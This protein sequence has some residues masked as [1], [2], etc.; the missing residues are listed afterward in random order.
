MRYQF[1]R[2]HK[3][4][5]AALNNLERLI[6]QTDFC[7]PDQVGKVEKTFEDLVNMLQ[8]HAQY[9]N[10]RLH[11]LLKQKNV[12]PAIYSH[13]EEDHI[14]QDQQLLKLEEILRVIPLQ[15]TNDKKIE[16]GH[17]L[18]LAYR[19]FVADNLA[20]LHEE[21]IQILPTLQSLY[22]DQELRQVEAQTYREMTP[23]EMIEMIE[24]LFP[25]MNTY[26]KQAFLF[27]IFS[28]EPKKFDAVLKAI[29]PLLS[30]SESN[31]IKYS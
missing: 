19:K 8:G 2:E 5:S 17:H 24:T 23:S 14:A 20:H 21:E 7:D 22:S 4:V 31:A 25:H 11:T 6:A 28:L 26:D 12:P 10:E 1:Y 9:E 18:H 27:D 30:E 16:Q 13:V 3:Y 29:Q 15:S